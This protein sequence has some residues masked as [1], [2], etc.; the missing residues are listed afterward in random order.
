MRLFLLFSKVFGVLNDLIEVV[1]YLFPE[2]KEGVIVVI[3]F[4]VVV[5]TNLLGS[6]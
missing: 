2:L 4:A 3:V 6:R 5:T 1:L